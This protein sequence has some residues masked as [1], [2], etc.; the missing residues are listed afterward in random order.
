MH[1]NVQQQCVW[2]IDCA[3]GNILDTQDIGGNIQTNVLLNSF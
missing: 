1:T 3:W 2:D